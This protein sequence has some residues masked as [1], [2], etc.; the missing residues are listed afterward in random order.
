MARPRRTRAEAAAAAAAAHKTP[1]EENDAAPENDENAPPEE[2]GLRQG[3]EVEPMKEAGKGRG[4]RKTARAKAL[5]PRRVSG[6]RERSG[7]SAD[8][9]DAEDAKNAKDAEDASDAEDAEDEI[10]GKDRGVGKSG[11]RRMSR[12]RVRGALGGAGDGDGDRGARIV[13]PIQ[14]AAPGDAGN[15]AE[16]GSGSPSVERVGRGLFTGLDA[17][18]D[19]GTPAEF[20]SKALRR[21]RGV[22]A[23]PVVVT[24]AGKRR[25]RGGPRASIELVGRRESISPAAGVGEEGDQE[26]DEKEEGDGGKKGDGERN[27]GKKDVE[28]EEYWKRERAYWDDIDDVVLEEASDDGDGG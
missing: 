28:L 4:K 11:A 22:A 24:Y 15:A 21:P 2:E 26:G 25:R 9:K 10:G 13:A 5:A 6:R 8:A 16:P 27:M 23:A 12:S 19:D 3:K 14:S 1:A 20:I 17:S 7:R 18:P